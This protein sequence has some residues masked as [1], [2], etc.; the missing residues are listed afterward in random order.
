MHRRL[1]KHVE[2][3]KSSAAGSLGSPEATSFDI[4]YMQYKLPTDESFGGRLYQVFSKES[5]S[6]RKFSS[7]AVKAERRG[8]PT[9]AQSSGSTHGLLGFQ[10]SMPL[11][12]DRP[13]KRKRRSRVRRPV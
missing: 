10:G 13:A 5:L 2:S 3:K 6:S 7:Y 12:A 4:R 1:S 8:Q 11:H 9:G